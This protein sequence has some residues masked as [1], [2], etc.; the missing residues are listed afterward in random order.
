MQTSEMDF[1]LSKENIQPL[2]GGRNA[3]QLVIALQ[4]Q[5]NQDY[6]RELLQQKEA[7]EDAIRAYDGD[8]PLDNWYNYI[9]WIEQSYPKHGY[10]G[11]LKALLED[12]LTKFEHDKKYTDDRRFCKLWIKFID[13]HQN[14]LDLYHMLYTKGIGRGCADL[15]RA[16]AY[17][18]EA[19]GDYKGA[20][21][22]FQR[23]EKELA[24]PFNDLMAAHQ[25]M[26]YAAGQQVIKGVD[27]ERL[28]EQRQALTCLRPY[29]HGV[30]GSVRTPSSSNP[31]T[32]GTTLQPKTNVS[33]PIFEDNEE[34]MTD[35]A[36]GPVSV[37]TIAK[38]EEGCKENILKPGPWT[39][40]VNHQL[41]IP[42]RYPPILIHEDSED[43][44]Q[45]GLIKPPDFY[46]V[47]H[48]DFSNFKPSLRYP[49]PADPKMC[50]KYPKAL[51]YA[52]E[53][54][55]YSIEEIK[56]RQY[57]I[58][59]NNSLR[60]SHCETEQAIQSILDERQA[61]TG[62]IRKS[63]SYLHSSIV[64]QSNQSALYQN[65]DYQSPQRPNDPI[66]NHS[67]SSNK[68][69]PLIYT[70]DQENQPH[71][72][73]SYAQSKENLWPHPAQQQTPQ[74]APCLVT[75][76]HR[77]QAHYCQAFMTIDDIWRSPAESRNDYG[78]TD[79][80]Q[81]YPKGA[82]MKTPIKI[83]SDDD[84][85]ETGSRGGLDIAAAAQPVD[86]AIINL[87]EDTNSS[88][89]DPL[90]YQGMEPQG[91]FDVTSTQMFNFNLTAMK[92]S[93]PVAERP[94]ALVNNR[95]V[96]SSKKQL[97]NEG[98][99]V[100]STIFEETKSYGLTSSSGSSLSAQSPQNLK[101]N[102]ALRSSLL[103]EYMDCQSQQSS[104]VTEVPPPI[105]A[106]KPT[107]ITPLS[108]A[109]S[110]PFQ[111]SLIKILLERINFP[112]QHTFGYRKLYTVP[113]L[114]IKKEMVAIGDDKYFVEKMLGKGT[115]GSVFKAIDCQSKQVVALKFQKPAN[116]WEYYV[117]RELQARLADH[118]LKEKF[119]DVSIG[120]F[121]E[122]ASI[123]VSDFSP[124]GSLLDVANAIKQ[125][126]GRTMKETLCV[127]FC[128]EMLEIVSAM[129]QAK[130]IHADVKPDNF[131]VRLVD[132]NVS[133]QL[134]DFGCGIDMAMFPP[135]TTF[136]RRV[137]TEDFV[138]CE[139]HDG[140]PWSYHT[141]LFC[142][143][144][145]AHVLLFD[146]YIQMQKKDGHWSI[147]QRFTR[148]W[149]VDCWNMFFSSLLNQQTGPA[150]VEPLVS[151]FRSVVD[152]S[153]DDFNTEMRFLV[154]LLKGR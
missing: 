124:N 129:H 16:W 58:R 85:A 41:P 131:L 49:E 115:Y 38:R 23:G 128:I 114:N 80:I 35:A 96:E 43:I 1:D 154:N 142:V 126:S 150:K 153:A 26:V 127:H 11:N 24:Q 145:T 6:Q 81:M 116:K 90:P 36:A 139:M 91:N 57:L 4:A 37:V 64:Q 130:I 3:S 106:V 29:R 134:I 65:A 71:L 83:L 27:K 136:N 125:K 122:Q 33:V 109:P 94:N 74:Q 100:L 78:D 48:E 46:P 22:V 59:P 135:D 15:Y 62:A 54:I 53:N 117:C 30:I 7:F 112:G 92:V 5:N 70:Q 60:V 17:Y 143:A 138:C 152:L 55:E 87:D 8:D 132:N 99:K 110:D 69:V 68:D 25:N 79:V 2:R 32:I 103:G 144:A 119:M 120:Y 137:R 77:Q 31:G 19:L 102:A 108:K 50:P 133:L 61:S 101:A 97:F 67:N 44:H 10:E 82:S 63:P 28:E 47:T 105:P 148:Y 95:E 66:H 76:P 98:N 56:A 39:T 141:D 34:Y 151:M 20:D 147:T 14:P 111:G 88:Y 86:G 40:V 118:P 45:R 72:S 21:L 42:H 104:P 146:K 93:T 9:S 73:A 140:R 18:Y 113:R 51:V 149:R 12:C 123:L 89:G 107:A 52:E 121:N 84:L 13:Y 75:S